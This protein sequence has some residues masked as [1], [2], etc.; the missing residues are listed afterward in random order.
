MLSRLNIDLEGARACSMFQVWTMEVIKDEAMR[1][2]SFSPPIHAQL[3]DRVATIGDC[4]KRLFAFQFQVLLQSPLLSPSL[5]PPLSP[6]NSPS[7]SP[8]R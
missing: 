7:H 4:V 6:S 2:S 8:S 1:A 5:S 3:N